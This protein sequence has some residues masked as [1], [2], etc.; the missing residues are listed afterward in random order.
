MI[1]TTDYEKVTN[2]FAGFIIN[3]NAHGTAIRTDASAI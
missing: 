3:R 1:K 2:F